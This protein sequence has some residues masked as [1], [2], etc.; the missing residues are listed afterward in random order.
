MRANASA[1]SGVGKLFDHVVVEKELRRAALPDAPCAC[2][3]ELHLLVI[4]RQPAMI[5]AHHIAALRFGNDF[6]ILFPHVREDGARALLI[7][8]ANLLRATQEDSAQDELAH[9]LRV[10]LGVSQ[11]ERAAPRAAEDLPASR[12]PDARASVR[13]PRRDATSYSLQ[14][15]RAACFCLSR[16]GRKGRR[17]RL[18]GRRT[19]GTQGRFRRPARRAERPRAAPP[20]Y[21]TA[22]NKWC[23]RARPP[24]CLDRKAQSDRREFS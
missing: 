4:A 11:R 5:G 16:A 6:Q 19:A 1:N 22:R 23:E 10:R 20:G 12:C 13:Y 9:A 8:P 7:K 17:D 3:F 21:R 2:G 15:S 14:G 18:R 24:A